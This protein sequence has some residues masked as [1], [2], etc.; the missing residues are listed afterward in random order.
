MRGGEPAAPD[1]IADLQAFLQ[2]R[3][4]KE[5][6]VDSDIFASGFVDSLFALELITF[7]ENQYKISVVS[8]DLD[9]DNFRTVQ[10]LADFVNRKQAMSELK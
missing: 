6:S 4:S 10:R 2:A 1:V 9:F 7:V 5:W 8:E 3:T